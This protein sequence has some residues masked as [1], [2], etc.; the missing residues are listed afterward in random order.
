MKTSANASSED[1]FDHIWSYW[2]RCFI[3][4]GIIGYA[5]WKPVK[6]L[7]NPSRVSSGL[8]CRTMNLRKTYRPASPFLRIAAIATPLTCLWIGSS[9]ALV[10]RWSKSFPH[11]L[12]HKSTPEGSR[13]SISACISSI[14]M[15][16]WDNTPLNSTVTANTIRPLTSPPQCIFA[17][18]WS[19]C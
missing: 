1:G 18:S 9:M 12:N 5:R 6:C 19:R 14:L 11:R 10:I 7:M 16:T 3:N 15:T 13:P 2:T 4:D 17:I 8:I